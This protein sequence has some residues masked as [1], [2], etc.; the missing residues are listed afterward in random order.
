MQRDADTLIATYA[1][2]VWAARRY[3]RD[4]PA[5]SRRLGK[6]QRQMYQELGLK[7]R[8]FATVGGPYVWWKLLREKARLDRGWTYEP[9]TFYEANFAVSNSSR[10]SG[11]R[12]ELCRWVVTKRQPTT[13]QQQAANR[14]VTLDLSET[15]DVQAVGSS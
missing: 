4:Q 7:A 6:L 5:M 10:L 3:Y 13:I 12:P 15:Q 9:P 8:L 2:A 14:P 1:A 11:P